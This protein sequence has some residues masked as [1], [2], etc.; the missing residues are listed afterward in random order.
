M[1]HQVRIEQF[2]RS[3]SVAADQTILECALF[4]GIDYPFACQQGQCGSCK[5]LLV[6]GEVE[7]GDRYNPLAL[8][9][10][11]RARGL[12][13]ACQARPRSDCVV[14]VVEI[15]GAIVHAERELECTVV[16]TLSAGPTRTI[17]A[18]SIDRGGPF[19]FVAGQFAVVD[20]T[21]GAAA[22]L[23]MANAPEAKL[24]EFHL[25]HAAGTPPAA[26]P[27]TR[28][29]VR[30][31]YGQAYLHDEHLGPI[32]AAC[33]AFGLAP[34]L[35]IVRSAIALGMPQRI[36]LHVDGDDDLAHR[37]AADPT[38]APGRGRLH[39]LP[40][41]NTDAL[42]ARIAADCADARAY[43]AYAGGRGS[44]LESLRALLISHSLDPA[45]FSAEEYP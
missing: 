29:K 16:D 6:A 19:N 13:L 43:R 9:T 1:A 31:P 10:D 8:S 44:F 32:L 24:L 36:Y 37:L 28:A 23:A 18:L 15:G 17:V 2:G 14:S 45:N 5:S 39:I 41:A 38:L 7:L 22:R 12:I 30:G 27:G 25:L 42:I 34:M 33:D 40:A 21:G 20:F 26:A 35:A 4:E 3:I 11:E